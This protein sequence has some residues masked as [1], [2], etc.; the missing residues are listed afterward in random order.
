MQRINKEHYKK[1]IY[2]SH[3]YGGEE[4]N[5]REI[6]NIIRDCRKQFPDYLFISPCHC[7]SFLYK[8]TDYIEGILMCL[9]LLENVCDEMWY[10]PDEKSKGV[11]VE[12]ETCKQL[13][14]PHYTLD[15]VLRKETE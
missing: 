9:Y 6:E 15:S 11:H 1:V 2:I 14:I 10:K 12:V 8:E 3:A 13:R 7:F 5:L 4:S